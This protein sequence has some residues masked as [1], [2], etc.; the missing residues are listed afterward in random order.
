MGRYLDRLKKSENRGAP[1]LQNQQNPTP[2]SFVGFVGTAPGTLEKSQ[3]GS[4][5]FVGAPSPTFKKAEEDVLAL[6]RADYFAHKDNCPI[7]SLS[8]AAV[9]SCE[10]HAELWL[11]YHD[12]LVSV[13][14]A[15]LVDGLPELSTEPPAS[16]D[17]PKG[18]NGYRTV[19]TA[20][21][22]PQS[23]TVARDAYH[24]HW[25]TCQRCKPAGVC[26]EGAALRGI[27]NQQNSLTESIT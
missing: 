12:A 13:H 21:I 5:G 11:A 23:W 20:H 8:W 7:C 27:Y 3:G 17:A 26:D 19:P 14:G 25:F 9:T 16:E 22:K 6:V 15:N 2:Y 1:Y 24:H 10:E 18:T 4:V